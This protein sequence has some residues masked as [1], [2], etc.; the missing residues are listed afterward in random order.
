M[1]KYRSSGLKP[2]DPISDTEAI[3]VALTKVRKYGDAEME[4][5]YVLCI[6]PGNVAT[7]WVT[8]SF[9]TNRELQSTALPE[10]KPTAYWGHYAYSWEEAVADFAERT[11]GW[12]IDNKYPPKVD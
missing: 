7:P 5:G 12:P 6:L 2:G 8:W 9:N 3:I 1:N 11:E 10:P 4:H